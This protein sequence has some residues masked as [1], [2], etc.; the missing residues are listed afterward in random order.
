MW[1]GVFWVCVVVVWWFEVFLGGGLVLAGFWVVFFWVC[2]GLV[3]WFEF[4]GG[5]GGF[6]VDGVCVGVVWLAVVC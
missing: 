1:F 2:V 3:L 5:G 6:R 4:I